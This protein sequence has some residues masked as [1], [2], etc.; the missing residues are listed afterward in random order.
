MSELN[1]AILGDKCLSLILPLSQ[2]S[3]GLLTA[4]LILPHLI[5]S[6][7]GVY[8]SVALR[9]VSNA[10]PREKGDVTVLL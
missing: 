7:S 3:V 6:A 9:D 2:V 10:R 1:A 4:H 5:A 8:C